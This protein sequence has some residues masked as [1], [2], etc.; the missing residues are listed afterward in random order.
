[1]KIDFNRLDE[2]NAKMTLVIEFDDYGPKLEE[3]LKKYSKKL[4]IK[5]FRAGKTPKTVLSKMYG[6]GLL[7]ETVNTMLNDKL[8]GYLEENKIEIFGSPVMADDAE[9]IDFN[10]KAQSDYTFIFDLGLK[11]AF[12]LKYETDKPV[13]IAV[14]GIDQAALD[15]DVIRY[16]RVFGDEVKVTGGQVEPND[17]VVVSLSA[18]GQNGEIS[19]QQVEA[20]VDLER[21]TG[22]APKTLLNLTEGAQFDTDLEKFLGYE[23]QAIIKNTLHLEHDPAPDTPLLYSVTIKEIKRPQHTELTGEQLSK[24][25]GRPMQ[26]EAEFRQFLENRER[27]NSR[28]QANEMKKMAVRRLLQEANPFGIPEPFLLK[29]VNHQRDKKITEGSR[30]ARQLFRDAKWSLLLNRI[31]T[32]ESLEV[33]EKDVQRQVTDWVIRNVN[34]MQTDIKKLMDQLYANEY[35]MSS[36]KENALEDVVFTHLLPKYTFEE[37]EVTPAEFEKAYHDIHHELFEHDHDHDHDHDHH[38]HEHSHGHH[39]HS[40]G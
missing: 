10:P 4:A 40:H 37:K 16:R 27:E 26:D 24:V 7:E 28:S 11:P 22:E 17:R 8:F 15:E 2:L 30:E 3:N 14:P 19:D 25:T 12:Q 32:A 18:I 35:F 5:G 9:P 31:S 21:S 6:K 13:Q 34:Y 20:L 23:R 38:H 1:M 33:T 36:M 39:E 29:W